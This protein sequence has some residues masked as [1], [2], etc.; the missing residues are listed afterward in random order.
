MSRRAA[1][2]WKCPLARSSAQPSGCGSRAF[3]ENGVRP[4]SS[5]QDSQNGEPW[6]RRQLAGFAP[7]V[8]HVAGDVVAPVDEGPVDALGEDHRRPRRGRR[9]RVARAA[10]GLV[11]ALRAGLRGRARERGVGAEPVALRDGRPSRA[12]SRAG[13][14]GTAC[15]APPRTPAGGG[16]RTCTSP[17]SAASTRRRPA[18]SARGGTCAVAA[19]LRQ[20]V[21]VR[22]GEPGGRRPTRRASAPGRCRGSPCRAPLRRAGRHGDVPHACLELRRLRDGPRGTPCTSRRRPRGW[23]GGRCRRAAARAR[24]PGRACASTP[25]R[26]AATPRTIGSFAFITAPPSSGRSGCR[27]ASPSRRRSARGTGSSRREPATT[28]L[29]PFASSTP[30]VRVPVTAVLSPFTSSRKRWPEHVRRRE[31]PAELLRARR[32]APPT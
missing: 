26:R 5:W 10:V 9:R 27:R 23:S 2:P 24:A 20:V 30:P 7:G 31:V 4:C 12:G 17:S 32:A 15:S 1:S 13:P 25:P 19:H 22:E 21:G 6:Q 18:R 14:C 11:V 16:G 28:A 29:K 3:A 8:D